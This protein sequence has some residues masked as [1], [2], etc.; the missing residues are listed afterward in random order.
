MNTTR[1][2]TLVSSDRLDNSV[3]ITFE[4]GRCAVYSAKLLDSIFSQADEVDYSDT[5]DGN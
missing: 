1:E 3:I 4:D 2:P 5:K